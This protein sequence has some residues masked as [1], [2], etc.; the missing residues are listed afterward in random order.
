MI[1]ESKYNSTPILEQAGKRVIESKIS[2]ELM[3][4]E[5]LS[6]LDRDLTSKDNDN[7]TD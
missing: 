3:I 2:K 4:A 7:D 1:D 5:N 6:T